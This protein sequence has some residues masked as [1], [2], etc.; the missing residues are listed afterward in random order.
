M[1]WDDI[2]KNS[3]SNLKISPLEMKPHKSRKYRAI[4]DLSFALKL[5]EWDLPSVNE[6]TKE[7]EPAEVIEQ[8]GTVMLHIVKALATALISEDPIHF[9]KLDIKDGFWRMVGVFGEE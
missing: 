8:V 1:R 6:A 9:S 4:L 5:A 2:K 7:T 3:P